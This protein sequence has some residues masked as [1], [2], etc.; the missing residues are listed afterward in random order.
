MYSCVVSLVV[1]SFF[2]EVFLF[3]HSPSIRALVSLIRVICKRMCLGFWMLLFYFII[4]LIEKANTIMI[5][6]N[7]KESPAAY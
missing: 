2:T 3:R 6:G 5:S 7:Q 4:L 1:V